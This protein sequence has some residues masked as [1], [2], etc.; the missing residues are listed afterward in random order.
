MLETFG[1]NRKREVVMVTVHVQEQ[2]ERNCG[3]ESEAVHTERE[4]RRRKVVGVQV[5]LYGY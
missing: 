5:C 1:P 2:I 3:E 4:K